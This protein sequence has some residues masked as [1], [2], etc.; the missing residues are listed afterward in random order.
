MI[1][2]IYSHKIH[3]KYDINAALFA[4]DVSKRFACA[5]SLDDNPT[6]RAA[7][8]KK[9][10]VEIS[11]G[12][13]LSK[14]LRALLTGITRGCDHGGTKDGGYGVPKDV[15]EILLRKGVK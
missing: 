9:G 14:E 8:K 11:F 2:S 7:L 1:L 5:A 15:I 10:Y 3:P 13:H 4:N 6:G 12:G